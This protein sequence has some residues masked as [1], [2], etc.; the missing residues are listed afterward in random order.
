[1]R[2]VAAGGGWL[3]P[4]VVPTL[5]A[6]V[7]RAPE[8]TAVMPTRL[9]RLTTREREVLVLLGQGL[10]NGEI[11]QALWLGPGTVKTHISRILH[12]TGCRDRAQAI[13]LAYATGLVATT[14]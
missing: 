10:D 12:K 2:A 9:T 4:T 5:L 13:V 1:M 7:R 8:A 3:D 11:A 6:A 14:A